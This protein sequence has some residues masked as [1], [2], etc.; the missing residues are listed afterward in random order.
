[1]KVLLLAN[2]QNDEQ[3]SM[4]RFAACLADGLMQASHQVRT[5]KPPAVAGALYPSWRGVGKWLGYVD[6]FA[7][8]PP[9]LKSAIQWADVTHICDHSN[10]FYVKHM[11]G[12][13]HIVT[14][15][16]LLAVRSALGEIPQ[17]RTPWTGRRLQGLILKGLIGAQ[18]LACVSEAT[19][20]DL[21]RVTGVP[22]QRVSRVYNCLNYP[23]SSMEPDEAACRI[24][25]LGIDP[26]RQF[27]LHVGGNQWYKNRLGVLRIFFTVRQLPAEQNLHLVMAGK[28][29]TA[30]MRRFV[31]EHKLTEA[32][33]ELTDVA[34]EDLRALY[35]R[36]A[37]LIF[38][39]LQE[40]FGWPIIEAQACGCPVLTSN[41]P[42]MNEVGSNAAIYIDPE[43]ADS[44]ATAIRHS[45]DTLSAMR[46]LG[47]Q[48]AAR[49][50]R[51]AM[52]D[53]YVSLYEKV[54]RPLCESSAPLLETVH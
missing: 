20:Q 32:A 10:A 46:E 15:H 18:H 42:P 29:W 44:T 33:L 25:A 36:A 34:D 30:A 37:M 50:S 35:S 27:L 28:P 4:Q 5:L 51:A 3:N 40:G 24:R 47:L 17:N 8:F 16:D 39:S 19:R 2:Y 45:F 26:H 49:F 48:N 21:L 54:Q 14:C 13:P 43:D 9:V 6:K 41:R 1:M 11:R 7:L 31:A 22:A 53:A 38:P 52:I 23:F 12:A